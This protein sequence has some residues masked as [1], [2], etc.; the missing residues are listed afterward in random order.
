MEGDRPAEG[1][2]RLPVPALALELKAEVEVGER[3]CGMQLR[4]AQEDG[5]RAGLVTLSG[6]GNAKEHPCLDIP[7]IRESRGLEAPARLVSVPGI[8]GCDPAA[9]KRL[10]VSGSRGL[11]PGGFDGPRYHATIDSQI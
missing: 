10:G 8:L 1:F 9:D 3:V 5:G 6:K 7:R 11:P 4:G 2:D